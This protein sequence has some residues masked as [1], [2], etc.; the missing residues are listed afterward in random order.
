MTAAASGILVAIL[1]VR[2]AKRIEVPLASW[3]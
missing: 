3:N 1:V 2:R